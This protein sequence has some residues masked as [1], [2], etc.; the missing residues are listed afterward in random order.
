MCDVGCLSRAMLVSRS[1]LWS[2]VY[3]RG[4]N[5][6]ITVPADGLA[7]G[8]S[9]G[10]VLATKLQWFLGNFSGFESTFWPD[11]VIQNGIYRS[12]RREVVENMESN[13]SGGSDWLPLWL[14]PVY[15]SYFKYSLGELSK[16]RCTHWSFNITM[17]HW[18]PREVVLLEI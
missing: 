16:S 12:S 15:L 1:N 18:Y 10:T 5:S 7:P 13:R 14:C 3:I 4:P 11:D 17:I 6:V 2:P 8:P 9:A